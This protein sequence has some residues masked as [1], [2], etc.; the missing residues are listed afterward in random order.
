MGK[1]GCHGACGAT[2]AVKWKPVFTSMY[3]THQEIM[4]SHTS[5]FLRQ[6]LNSQCPKNCRHVLVLGARV[7]RTQ[8]QVPVLNV[9]TVSCK[10]WIV[11]THCIF[12]EAFIKIFYFGIIIKYVFFFIFLGNKIFLLKYQIKFYSLKLSF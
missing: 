5:I 1:L 12:K 10:T 6:K 11:L 9:L 2:N 4:L 8:I 7:V 3:P